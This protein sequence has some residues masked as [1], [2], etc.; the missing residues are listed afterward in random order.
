MASAR[1]CERWLPALLFFL[2]QGFPGM[3]AHAG[4]GK[5]GVP[6]IHI[7][8]LHRPHV[9]PDDHWDLACVYALAYR[10]D[11]DSKAS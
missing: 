9:D 6:V 4:Q 2:A 3:S 8:D 5:A 7:T 11:I 10:G 1:A